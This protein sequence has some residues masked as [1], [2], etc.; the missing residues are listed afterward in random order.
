MTTQRTWGGRFKGTL[1]EAMLRLSASV[2][3]DRALA[4]DDIL[5]SMAHARALERAKVLTADELRQILNGLEVVRDEVR[6]GKMKWDA[7][8]EDVHMNIEARLTELVGPLG[9]K[10]HT[11]RSRNDQVATDLRLWAQ[12]CG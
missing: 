9:G 12:A 10:L 2:D 7:A 11:G 5:G 4:E 8:L 6:Q 1:A 3:V